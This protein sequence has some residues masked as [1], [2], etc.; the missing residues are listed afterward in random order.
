MSEWREI[1][2]RRI[3]ENSDQSAERRRNMPTCFAWIAQ[4]HRDFPGLRVLYASENGFE[5][6]EKQMEGVPVSDMVFRKPGEDA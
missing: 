2:Q 3:A 1:T 5:Y 6:G 4:W